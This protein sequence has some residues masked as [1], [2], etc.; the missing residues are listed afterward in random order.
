MFKLILSV[1]ITLSALFIGQSMSSRL[2]RRRET[3]SLFIRNLH[4]AKVRLNYDNATIYELFDD[5][6]FERDKPFL[7]QW[8]TLISGYKAVLRKKDIDLLSEFANSLGSSDRESQ[9]K[10]MDLYIT[11]LEH[12]LQDAQNDIIK[13]AK[14]YR[15]LGFSAGVTLSLMLI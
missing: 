11:L 1:M 6:T 5:F 2:Y 7:P 12:Q 9:I 8:N 3:I 10:H 15:V 4:T 14:L 13:K